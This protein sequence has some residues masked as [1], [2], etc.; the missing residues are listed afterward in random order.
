VVVTVTIVVTTASMVCTDTGAEVVGG[1]ADVAGAL[2]EEGAGT[3]YDEGAGATDP[4]GAGEEL[5]VWPLQR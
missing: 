4:T 3:L 2:Y 1:A 5:A